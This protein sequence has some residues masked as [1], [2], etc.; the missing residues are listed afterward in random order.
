MW[1][2]WRAVIVVSVL[3][4]ARTIAIATEAAASRRVSDVAQASPAIVAGT[5]DTAAR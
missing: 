1:G 4:V 3:L 2:L 5:S